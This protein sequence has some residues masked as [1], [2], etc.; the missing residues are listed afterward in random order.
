[1]CVGEGFAV[2]SEADFGS[3]Q[4]GTQVTGNISFGLMLSTRIELVEIYFQDHISHLLSVSGFS[5]V[6]EK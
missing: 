6:S 3:I 4:T 1:M 5:Q 2:T